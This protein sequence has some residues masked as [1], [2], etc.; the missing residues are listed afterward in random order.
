MQSHDLERRTSHWAVWVGERLRELEV[1]VAWCDDEF[2]ILSR[3]R[4]RGCEIVALPLELRRLLGAMS[5]HHR[6]VDPVD[7]LQRA[8]LGHRVGQL[9]IHVQVSCRER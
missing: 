1:V 8:E 2:Y 9:E 4:Q 3:R 7:V 5:E 6:H